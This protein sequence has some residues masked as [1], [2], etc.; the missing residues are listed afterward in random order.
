M[1]GRAPDVDLAVAALVAAY[2]AL[3]TLLLSLNLTALWRW[4]IKAGAIALT[5]LFFLLTWRAIPSLIGWPTTERLPARFNVVWT[6]VAEPD[7]RTNDPGAIYVWAQELDANNVPSSR[8]RSYQLPY[9]DALARKIAEVQEKR[10][11]GQEVMG[12]LRDAGPTRDAT[13]RK[14]IRMGQGKKGTEQNSA[15][16]TVPFMDADTRLGFQDLPPV[17]LPDKGPL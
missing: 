5:M 17:L 1:L 13:P 2:V 16:D 10:E 15:V 7:R 6:T 4:W 3:A 8:P 12:T 11:H 9:S 14:D